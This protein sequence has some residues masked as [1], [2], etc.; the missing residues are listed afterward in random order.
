MKLEPTNKTL[1]YFSRDDWQIKYSLAVLERYLQGHPNTPRWRKRLKEELKN[2]PG[3]DTT[4][5]FYN[6]SVIP[7]WAIID[8]YALTSQQPGLKNRIFE[9][10][11]I[12]SL[13]T[14]EDVLA[15]PTYNP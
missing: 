9:D 4:L 6:G 13:P 14:L 8:F 3:L 2:F 11:K 15:S 7:R 12:K 10:G 5:V 1:K